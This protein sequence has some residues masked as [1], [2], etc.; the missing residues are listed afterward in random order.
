MVV[1]SNL[2]PQPAQIKL[3]VESQILPA[4]QL[5][6]QG[7]KKSS[8]LQ[9]P[10]ALMRYYL[11]QKR[12]EQQHPLPPLAQES[13]RVLRHGQKELTIPYIETALQIL[14]KIE[15]EQPAY[16]YQ[17]RH[18]LENIQG[19]LNLVKKG[20]E[21]LRIKALEQIEQILVRIHNTHAI[22]WDFGGVLMDGHNKFFI[23]LYA[24]S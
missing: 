14:E 13:E 15:E 23:E 24:R 1:T 7:L 4:I 17:D 6:T 21:Y 22:A 9:N 3:I 2:I 5:L 11:L 19:Y 8:I 10:R 20:P 16:Q 12:K 18:R